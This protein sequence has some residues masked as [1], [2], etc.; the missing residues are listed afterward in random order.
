MSK[1]VLVTT[2]WDKVEYDVG[3]ARLEE[4]K[5]NLWK[6]MIL[7][8]SKTFE[9]R[10]TRE[11]AIQLIQSIVLRQQET[12]RKGVQLQVEISDLEM[13]FRETVAG[14]ELCSSLEELTRRRKELLR[15]LQ[16]E[17]KRAD[18]QIS[19]HLRREYDELQAE[20]ESILIRGQALRMTKFQRFWKSIQKSWKRK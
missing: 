1:V 8:G 3:E 19:E 12:T 20:L 4:L 5:D 18:P 7:R 2:M 10:N 11:S 6:A 17:A 13:E 15:R 9:H 14:R 16:A